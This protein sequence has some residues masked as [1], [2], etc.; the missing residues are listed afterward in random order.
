MTVVA[1]PSQIADEITENKKVAVIGNGC[2]AT[3]FMPIVSIT[4][5]ALQT[6]SLMIIQIQIARRTKKLTQY[7]SSPQ[8]YVPRGNPLY[9]NVQKSLFRY[10]PGWM[11][12]YR[13]LIAYNWEMEAFKFQGGDGNAKTRK[14]VEDFFFAYM[15]ATAPAKYHK[16]LTPDYPVSSHSATIQSLV[17]VLTLVL[18]SSDAS[19]SSLI[20]I[21]SSLHADNVELAFTR[22]EKVF[23]NSRNTDMFL[24][25]A[26]YMVARDVYIPRG[27]DIYTCLVGKWFTIF[28]DDFDRGVAAKYL[29]EAFIVKDK[30][31]FWERAFGEWFS[32]VFFAL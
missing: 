3:Q 24:P 30:A 1:P 11:R 26:A 9:T 31:S 12:L 4:S 14:G 23:E 21:T 6:A 2:S 19:A 29:R 27:R 25:S 18:Y 8:W 7:V 32:K 28:C 20:P 5:L 15:K 22:V 13:L 17:M 16:E 10:V